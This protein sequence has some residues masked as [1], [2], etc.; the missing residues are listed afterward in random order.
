MTDET[1][2]GPKEDVYDSMKILKTSCNADCTS[3]SI[4]Y[5]LNDKLQ[6]VR[7]QDI[8]SLGSAMKRVLHHR[9]LQGKFDGVA[10][11]L[12][13]EGVKEIKIE[14]DGLRFNGFNFNGAAEMD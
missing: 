6:N 1:L 8:L 10:Q 2:K 12:G 4:K 11:F 14:E 3:Y 9:Y 5:A 7:P 13:K